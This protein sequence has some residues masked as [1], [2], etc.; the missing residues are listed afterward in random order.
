MIYGMFLLLGNLLSYWSIDSLSWTELL[1]GIFLG[2]WFGDFITGVVHITLDFLPAGS[3]SRMHK[4]AYRF[5]VH[6]V[7]ASLIAEGNRLFDWMQIEPFMSTYMVGLYATYVAKII[8]FWVA[9]LAVFTA[10]GS[11]NNVI[12]ILTMVAWLGALLSQIPHAMA[13]GKFKGTFWVTVMQKLRLFVP[14]HVHRHHHQT[15]D[16]NFTLLN[17]WA[18]PVLNLIYSWCILPY[19]HES[20]KPHHHIQWREEGI[21]Q[22]LLKM[23]HY[24]DFAEKKAQ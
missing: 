5:K 20:T 15:F 18:N 3:K 7:Q 11:L 22:S 6:H 4:L 17:G 23:T 1:L 19:V 2:L 16:C 9:G 13:H 14:P 12:S 24:E 8:S 21:E 10:G